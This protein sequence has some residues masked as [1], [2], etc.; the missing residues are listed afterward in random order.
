[1]TPNWTP[2]DVNANRPP[3]A[4]ILRI[5]DKPKELYKH[6]KAREEK[7]VKEEQQKSSKLIYQ[8]FKQSDKTDIMNRAAANPNSVIGRVH[9]AGRYLM[10]YLSHWATAIIDIMSRGTSI[11][12]GCYGSS[13]KKRDLENAYSS[14]ESGWDDRFSDSG[15]AAICSEQIGVLD[16]Y[17]NQLNKANTERFGNVKGKLYDFDGEGWNPQLRIFQTDL[18]SALPANPWEDLH[19]NR[20]IAVG[21]AADPNPPG[22]ELGEGYMP[23]KWHYKGAENREV[24][25]NPYAMEIIRAKAR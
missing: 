11:L 17:I 21:V 1:M 6:D 24:V 3:R 8:D 9:T 7:V 20:D 16:N 12:P 23:F 5:P 13:D 19:T 2:G 14:R 10:T 4:A 25:V 15:I 18:M 22:S